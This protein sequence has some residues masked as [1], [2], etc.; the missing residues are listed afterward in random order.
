MVA[1]L[2]VAALPPPPL[3]VPLALIGRGGARERRS[4]LGEAT[5]HG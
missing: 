4:H 2:I 3:A 5:P 1:L